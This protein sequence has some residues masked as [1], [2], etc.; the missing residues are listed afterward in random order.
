MRTLARWITAIA[1]A[2]V[3]VVGVLAVVD[4]R[5]HVAL[6]FL[7]WTTPEI[8]IYWWLVIAFALGVLVGWL[9]AGVRVVRAVAGNRRL[10]RD[11]DRS[12]SELERTKGNAAAS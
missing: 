4:N 11:L 12:R 3:A 9:S 2:F 10:R 5:D 7:A 1:F 6:H 8:S